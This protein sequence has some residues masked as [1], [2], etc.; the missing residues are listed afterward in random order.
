M[1]LR[2]SL[3]FSRSLSLVLHIYISISIFGVPPIFGVT[4]TRPW[5]L[6][7]S[8]FSKDTFFVRCKTFEYAAASVEAL[9]RYCAQFG[10]ASTPKTRRPITISELLYCCGRAAL[11]FW[12]C[13]CS[14]FERV[15]LRVFETVVVSV[16]RTVLPKVYQCTNFKIK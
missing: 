4:L 14:K 3:S 5:I 12:T 9:Q 16:G 10:W 1:R 13:S 7:C 15:S 6:I 11:S 8:G 2:I